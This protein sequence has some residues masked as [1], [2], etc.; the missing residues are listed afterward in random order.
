MSYGDFKD[1]PRRTVSDKV[2]RDKAFNITKNPKYDGYQRRLTSM[3][4]TSF[5]KEATGRSVTR[6]RSETLR[7]KTLATRPTQDKYTIE[8]KELVQELHKPI[9]KKLKN[10]EC[11]H[12]LWIIFGVLI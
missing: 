10:E 3:V 8:N 12:L 1:L 6:A 2:L 5:D 4:Y 7:S 9:I 11:T